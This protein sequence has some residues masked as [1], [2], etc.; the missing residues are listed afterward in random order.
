LWQPFRE[1]LRL[2]L[3]DTEFTHILL[4]LPISAAL[5]FS[6]WN[7]AKLTPSWSPWIGLFLGA[8]GALIALSPRWW[9]RTTPDVRL[10]VEMVALVVLWIAAFAL[11]FGTRAAGAMLFPLGFLF[12]MVPLPSFLL[13]RII[14][15]LQRGSAFAAG[16]LF[17]AFNIPISRQGIVLSIPGLNLEVARE[18]SSIRSSLMLLI[19]TMV[20]AHVLLRTGW[21][22]AVVVAVAVPLS[23]AKNGLRIFAI[24]MLATR[25][26]PS[27]LTGRLHH[28]GGG[29]FFFIALVLIALLVWFLHRGEEPASIA[30]LGRDH[31]PVDELRSLPASLS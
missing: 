14:E 22:K 21:R 7:S 10:S 23:V 6:Q 30:R 31:S 3:G 24:G 17:S 4:I 1:T 15:A 29:A 2:A 25:V 16:L 13:M 27:F 5:T 9:L 8:T 26:D 20:L 19:T 18:C 12:W 11:S 28:E